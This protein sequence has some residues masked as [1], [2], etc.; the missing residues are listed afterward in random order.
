MKIGQTRPLG[1]SAGVSRL[2]PTAGAAPAT[3]VA[4]SAPVS[5][6]ASVMGIPEQEFTPKV[7]EAI[8][9]LLEEV[10]NLRQELEESKKRITHLEKLAD[11]D[12]L[13]PI[14]N[15]RSFVRELSRMLAYAQRYGGEISVLYFDINDM[16]S[17]ND[18]HGHAAGDAAI[19]HVA[20]LLAANIRESDVVG[21]L[22]GDEFGI[23]LAN[24]SELEAT[25]IAENLGKA[26]SATP[27]EWKG[28]DLTVSIS[29][30]AYALKGGEDASAMLDQA[31]QAMY[32]RKPRVPQKTT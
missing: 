28:R 1:G 25:Q 31:D 14:S 26:I 7:R 24:A 23:I 20:D 12:A 30:G 2:R 13:V 10:S 9:S 3:T 29:S 18:A 8:V 19:A 11:E 27:F 4:R 5:D 15:R 6:S 22:G 17:I 32:A 16:K 21:R